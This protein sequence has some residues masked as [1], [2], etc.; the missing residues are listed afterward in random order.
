M[1]RGKMRSL[2]RLAFSPEIVLPKPPRGG[3]FRDHR[4]RARTFPALGLFRQDDVRSPPRPRAAAGSLISLQFLACFA[5]SPKCECRFERAGDAPRESNM[6]SVKSDINSP[7]MSKRNAADLT[8]SASGQPRHV[9]AALKGSRITA[10]WVAIGR[11]RTAASPSK[12]PRCPPGGA[13]A[14]P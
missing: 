8:Q 13:S 6:P 4:V 10:T 5:V 9:A 2:I 7:I 12:R 14:G 11:T 1:L 3:L